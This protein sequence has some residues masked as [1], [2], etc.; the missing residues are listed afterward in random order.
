MELNS[1][2]TAL[3]PTMDRIIDHAETGVNP[4]NG[5]HVTFFFLNHGRLE[6]VFLSATIV[7][8]PFSLL[9]FHTKIYD[10][11]VEYLRTRQEESLGL[12]R[13][14]CKSAQKL[15][16]LW[17]S[18]T[19]NTSSCDGDIAFADL[20]RTHS[21]LANKALFNTSYR[22]IESQTPLLSGTVGSFLKEFPNKST[23][24]VSLP[25]AETLSEFVAARK[26]RVLR[27][28]DG[29]LPRDMCQVSRHRCYRDDCR[30]AEVLPSTLKTML[31]SMQF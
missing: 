25:W 18:M 1:A 13:K 28:E 5:T 20:Y 12:I 4:A 9:G 16:A 15:P 7:Q 21:W 24:G 29:T 8:L 3:A 31:Q 6:E 26:P 2:L 17:L 30:E 14:A 23:S 27:A 10:T 22:E 11:T 19:Q